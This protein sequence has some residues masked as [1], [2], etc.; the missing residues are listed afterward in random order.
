MHD[1]S[2]SKL[3][4]VLYVGDIFERFEIFFQ[5]FLDTLLDEVAYQNRSPIGI[6]KLVSCS[7]NHP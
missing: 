2:T 6:V 5:N 3:G 7:K 4:V 1:L